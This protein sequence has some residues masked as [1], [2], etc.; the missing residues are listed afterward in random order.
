[1]KRSAAGKKFNIALY[2]GRYKPY[3]ADIKDRKIMEGHQ[4]AQLNMN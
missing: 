3:K 4:I 1:M 2:K